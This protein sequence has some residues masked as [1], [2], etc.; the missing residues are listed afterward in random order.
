MF[1]ESKDGNGA[2]DND[3]PYVP[4]HPTS[5]HTYPFS[6][7]QYARLLVLRS[8]VQNGSYRYDNDLVL[9]DVDPAIVYHIE[10]A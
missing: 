3:L 1:T 9:R 7:H 5:N 2:G 8:R 6:Q 10:I 4:Q